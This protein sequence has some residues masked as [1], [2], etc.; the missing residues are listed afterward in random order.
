MSSGRVS[1]RA[2][3]YARTLFELTPEEETLKHIRTLEKALGDSL[4]EEFLKSPLVSRK[5]KKIKVTAHTN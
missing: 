4:V 2:E 1:E 3:V 5:E